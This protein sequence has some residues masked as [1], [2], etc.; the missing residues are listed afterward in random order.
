MRAAPFI[1]VAAVTAALSGT[2][3]AQTAVSPSSSPA[4][5]SP[6]ADFGGATRSHW[7]AAGFV[8]TTFNTSSD[9]PLVNTNEH[10]VG[11]GGQAG[12]LWRGIVGGEFLADFAPDDKTISSLVADRNGSVN[13]YMG[14]AI[15][16]YPLG[17]KGQYQP[18]ASGGVG[19][20]A[21]GADVFN[22]ANDPN[23][24]T[25]RL[26]EGRFGW[27][28]GGGL[29]AFANHIGVRTDVRLYKASVDNNPP[30]ATDPANVRLAQALLSGLEFWRVNAGMAFRW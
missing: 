10:G 2:A 28:V 13:S 1:V 16:A 14:N 18:Y 9:N 29:M 11:F 30:S 17:A 21:V 6:A 24:G 19:R 23:S 8:G 20:V 26:R 5:Q 12:Y 27:N 7:V 25:D 4:V 15:G 3:T 22:V